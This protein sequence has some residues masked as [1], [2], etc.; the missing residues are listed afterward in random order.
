METLKKLSLLMCI[1]PALTLVYDLIFGWFVK[2]E[3]EIRSLKKWWEI[4]N[5]G[6]MLPV[7]NFIGSITSTQLADKIFNMPAPFVLG[8]IPLFLYVVYR[9]IFLLSGGKQGGYKSRH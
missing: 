4:I 7:K 1:P 5:K 8:A 3:F 9:I 6:S 2:A